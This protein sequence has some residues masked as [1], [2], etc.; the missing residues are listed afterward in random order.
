MTAS[1]TP[2]SSQI[3]D[4]SPAVQPSPNVANGESA[5]EKPTVDNNRT[6]SDSTAVEEP[7]FK[8]GGYGWSVQP[9]LLL[10]D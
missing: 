10:R 5:G 6:E 1:L 2:K 3:K 9:F 8:E 4:S 7:E